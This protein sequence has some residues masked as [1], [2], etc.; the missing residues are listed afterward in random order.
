MLYASHMESRKRHAP[1]SVYFNAAATRCDSCF[2]L[3][4]LV[5]HV[6]FCDAMKKS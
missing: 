1:L 4:V 3:C 5:F 6:E 2:R